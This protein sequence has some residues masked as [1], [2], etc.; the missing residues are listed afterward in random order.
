MLVTSSVRPLRSL[1]TFASWQ[2]GG[3]PFTGFRIFSLLLFLIELGR[4]LCT[5][6]ILNAGFIHFDY[7]VK[8]LNPTNGVL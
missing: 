4:L 7:S 1:D 6:W 5:R 2:L 3:D 8:R